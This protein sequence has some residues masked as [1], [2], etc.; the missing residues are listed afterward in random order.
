MKNQYLSNKK[1][2]ELINSKKYEGYENSIK[3]A[4]EFRYANLLNYLNKDNNYYN[5]ISIKLQHFINENLNF[6]NLKSYFFGFSKELLVH[7]LKVYFY[8]EIANN[9][10]FI[11]ELN[12]IKCDDKSVLN[13]NQN[14]FDPGFIDKMNNEYDNKM[15]KELFKILEENIKFIDMEKLH[16]IYFNEY[17]YIFKNILHILKS[18]YIFYAYTKYKIDDLE[19]EDNLIYQLFNIIEKK[20]KIQNF[21][22]IYFDT[23][24]D[25]NNYFELMK[26]TH[27][28]N[29]PWLYKYILLFLNIQIYCINI[30]FFL[31]LRLNILTKNNFKTLLNI[32]ITPSTNISKK[33]NF[34]DII[35]YTLK[36][37]EYSIFFL[38]ISVN[39]I[40][41]LDDINKYIKS[42]FSNNLFKFFLIYQ[43]NKNSP[44]IYEQNIQTLSNFLPHFH[45]I[46]TNFI[47]IKDNFVYKKILGDLLDGILVI[48]DNIS[49]ENDGIL[50]DQY[51]NNNNNNIFMIKNGVKIN[52]KNYELNNRDNDNTNEYLFDR[53]INKYLVK[54]MKKHIKKKE[55]FKNNIDINLF[56]KICIYLFNG[57][58][59]IL[60]VND[61]KKC[62][63]NIKTCLDYIKDDNIYQNAFSLKYFFNL[64]NY[65]NTEIVTNNIEITKHVSPYIYIESKNILLETSTLFF[66]YD[67]LKAYA[68]TS[69][70]VSNINSQLN[71]EEN[72]NEK[73]MFHPIILYNV[74]KLLL[75]FFANKICNFPIHTL[76]MF[77]HNLLSIYRILNVLIGTNA[78][79]INFEEVEN[80]LESLSKLSNNTDSII[81]ILEDTLYFKITNIL[82]TK[83]L[84]IKNIYITYIEYYYILIDFYSKYLY[85]NY[86]RGNKIFFGNNNFNFCFFKNMIIFFC[87]MLKINKCF[88]LLIEIKL[89]SYF[90]LPYGIQNSFVSIFTY[91][92]FLSLKYKELQCFTYEIVKTLLFLVKKININKL[93][94]YLFQIFSYSEHKEMER[95]EMAKNMNTDVD[96]NIFNSNVFLNN[97]SEHGQN[98]NDTFGNFQNNNM[99]CVNFSNF[100]IEKESMDIKENFRIDISFL[101]IYFLINDVKTV[102]LHKNLSN[103]ESE[104]NKNISKYSHKKSY[105]EEYDEALNKMEKKKMKITQQNKYEYNNF[106]NSN[107]NSY[108]K[109]V[110]S[111]HEIEEISF[112]NVFIITLIHLCEIDNNKINF[113]TDLLRLYDEEKKKN[114]FPCTEGILKLFKKVIN[115]KTGISFYSNIYKCFQRKI[116][117]ILDSIN[118]LVKKWTKW[119]FENCDNTFK[120]EKNIDINKLVNLFFISFYKY[121]KNYFLIINDFLN[122]IKIYNSNSTFDEFFFFIFSKY[123]NKVFI[124]N[125][126]SSFI[127]KISKFTILN[128]AL[129]IINYMLKISENVNTHTIKEFYTHYNNQNKLYLQNVK[130]E[131]SHIRNNNSSFLSY[132]YN[133]NDQDG[134]I[135]TEHTPYDLQLSKKN[136]ITF[137]NFVNNI[138]INHTNLLSKP[139]LYLHKKINIFQLHMA[140][141]NEYFT[142]ITTM[143]H[144]TDFLCIEKES[145]NNKLDFSHYR[146]N[147]E[148]FEKRYSNNFNLEYDNQVSSVE[149]L[150]QKPTINFNLNN[151]DFLENENTS[152]KNK[153][154]DKTRFDTNEFFEN[155]SVNMIHKNTINYNLMFQNF[156][157][158]IINI[159]EIIFQNNYVFFLSDFLLVHYEQ[160]EKNKKIFKYH[161]SNS[162]NYY[163]NMN[164]FINNYNINYYKNKDID[165]ENSKYKTYQKLNE[166]IINRVLLMY[167][168]I[169]EV[170]CR[171]KFI[172]K[173]NNISTNI[174]NQIFALFDTSHPIHNLFSKVCLNSLPKVSPFYFSKFFI[175]FHFFFIFFSFF[176]IFFH[177]FF[178]FFQFIILQND[179]VSKSLNNDILSIEKKHSNEKREILSISLFYF[180]MHNYKNI[181]TLYDNLNKYFCSNNFSSIYFMCKYRKGY[182]PL[183]SIITMFTGKIKFYYNKI[184]QV[185][186]KNMKIEYTKRILKI[187]KFLY[188][189]IRNNDLIDVSIYEELFDLLF[190]IITKYFEMGNNKEDIYKSYDIKSC[191][192]NKLKIFNLSL[193]FMNGVYLNLFNEKYKDENSQKNSNISEKKESLWKYIELH[194]NN[195]INKLKI[196]NYIFI[197]SYEHMPIYDKHVKKELYNYMYNINVISEIFDLVIK[198]LYTEEINIYKFI[199]QICY[200]RNMCNI[201]FNINYVNL[202][203]LLSSYC[204]LY[205]KKI[206]TANNVKDILS[207]N[208]NILIE[209]HGSISDDILIENIFQIFSEKNYYY[210]Y[211]LNLYENKAGNDQNEENCIFERKNNSLSIKNVLQNKMEL[212]EDDYIS[213]RLFEK[214]SKKKYGEKNFVF[215]I[216]NYCYCLNVQKNNLQNNTSVFN[217]HKENKNLINGNIHC[218]NET[219]PDIKLKNKIYKSILKNMDAIF[220]NK[221]TNNEKKKIK[222]TSLKFDENN[223]E[224]N[225]MN[226]WNDKIDRI[227]NIKN[228]KFEKIDRKKKDKK[229]TI[230]YEYSDNISK[231]FMFSKYFKNEIKCM[232]YINI[233]QSV[234]DSKIRLLLFLYKFIIILKYKKLFEIENYKKEEEFYLK[235]SNT[236]LNVPFV[237]FIY[238]A[239]CTFLVP[240][241]QI[242]KNS[243]YYV[244]ISNI[245]VNLFFI[246]NMHSYEQKK[247]K[248]SLENENQTKIPFIIN[249]NIENTNY[250]NNK[251]NEINNIDNNDSYFDDEYENS[252]YCDLFLYES[253][254]TNI[255]NN[256]NNIFYVLHRG[257][258]FISEIYRKQM[259]WQLQ[260]EGYNDIDNKNSKIENK[261]KKK[262]EKNSIEDS[263]MICNM[264]VFFSLFIR[265][266]IIHLHYFKLYNKNY[267]FL[268]NLN[269]LYVPNCILKHIYPAQNFNINLFISL[270]E[271]FYVSIRLYNNHF[272][273]IN[274]GRQ[275]DEDFKF[276][277]VDKKNKNSKQQNI[278]DNEKNKEINKKVINYVKNKQLDIYNSGD[279]IFNFNIYIRTLK[280]IL[281]ECYESHDMY[282]QNEENNKMSYFMEHILLYFLYNRINTIYEL[283]YSFYFK[284]IKVEKTKII[285]IVN[286]QIYKNLENILYDHVNKINTFLYNNQYYYFY[287]NTLILLTL[288]RQICLHIIKTDILTKFIYVPI[289]YHSMFDN[290]KNFNSIYYISNGEYIRNKNHITF[291]SLIVLIIKMLYIY[292]NDY[293]NF[294]ENAEFYFSENKSYNFSKK[295]KKIN[296]WNSE[297][298]EIDEMHTNS[299]FFENI[300]SIN[301]QINPKEMITGIQNDVTNQRNDY[302]SNNEINIQNKNAKHFEND[303]KNAKY[304]GKENL[305][306]R[307]YTNKEVVFFLSSIFN[308]IGKMSDRINF[309]FTKI[310]KINCL[311][312][313]EEAYLY[314]E[315]LTKISYY[316]SLYNINDFLISIMDKAVDHHLFYINRILE[317]FIFEKEMIIDPYS[318]YEVSA[319]SNSQDYINQNK[320]KKNGLSL[321]TQRILYICYKSI[322]NY[323]TIL[324]N[325]INN[326]YFYYSYFVIHF[327]I[328]ILK[329]TR[330]VT[331]IIEH[332]GRRNTTLIR[333]VKAN[334]GIS[335]VP[336]CLD[337]INTTKEKKKE[338]I[339]YT[340][341]VGGKSSSFC[342]YLSDNN[343]KS[344]ISNNSGEIIQYNKS[345]DEYTNTKRIYKNDNLFNFLPE[346]IQLKKYYN[347]LKEI[348]ER[349]AFLGAFLLEKLKI[350]CEDSCLK[351][352]LISN[353]CSYLIH[354]NATLLP[355][356]ICTNNFK[357]KCTLI[358]NYIVNIHKK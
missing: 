310:E 308:I 345:I 348:L 42:P 35:I 307:C 93:N 59:F 184:N 292:A 54:N 325:I 296:E 244:L 172:K 71:G 25:T 220:D 65:K 148:N 282:M 213:K 97:N 43:K 22:Q 196:N 205:N 142:N 81:T 331:T 333:T 198:G 284:C 173:I 56:L 259:N 51:I 203:N 185:Q 157:C 181:Y 186:C 57:E 39:N 104:Q 250:V 90:K 261:D 102:R 143:S 189:F 182:F 108:E 274:K 216:K 321:F 58:D 127:F 40:I 19:Y 46:L 69:T 301:L 27:T 133:E 134:N 260:N 208:K 323:N 217:L 248:N 1:I 356:N 245:I 341:G 263:K 190:F 289:I 55:F 298:I 121:L 18:C 228:N 235:K 124:D 162:D 44:N 201:F 117:Q 332:F 107:L 299:F 168:L 283:L 147:I 319:S 211:I 29:Y 304:K 140:N 20:I 47:F 338:K 100:K 62:Y 278:F 76:I 229:K 21:I 96:N 272:V 273:K 224:D 87:K 174:A 99:N 297:G 204:K 242:N 340:R 293:K 285:D 112:E 335:N 120:R 295:L 311:A 41:K 262:P 247:K 334:N 170:C 320:L 264:S 94:T 329:S 302:I 318:Q 30:F 291:C 86:D 13:D 225:K 130:V 183:L 122:N 98:N 230:Y 83:N 309:I 249:T 103:N 258:S 141:E 163:S 84:D 197:K 176:F 61:I 2:Y 266:I 52:N 255:K 200:N 351:Q 77:N 305:D 236:K 11:L 314:V 53:D 223:N 14:V 149:N 135:H 16:L 3:E 199:I 358:Y 180:F 75:E 132:P 346:V 336:I 28:E 353:I 131:K 80:N 4:F 85:N 17:F 32:F 128:T 105:N 303:N 159:L 5:I 151:N 79:L 271:V 15:D 246:I 177:F 146:N 324:L 339:Y 138:I 111:N 126:S 357:K 82:K 118:T 352:I 269:A 36:Q 175:F 355:A 129:Y 88:P 241:I 50:G 114:I 347:I 342:Q 254:S 145:V 6:G 281:T 327:Y 350:L 34:N 167:S 343:S 106:Y 23:Y 169:L 73:G 192:F 119:T 286:K 276:D 300:S 287:I 191:E 171:F 267:Y 210:K 24:N 214:K 256:N 240:S 315:L 206:D 38:L 221:N 153:N 328:L 316:C 322:L 277:E 89:F 48:D 67:Y 45:D 275:F 26:T 231:S 63:K 257:S 252:Y 33:N 243:F 251:Q 101:K 115:K 72:E 344:D 233:T 313:L 238:E 354:I 194:F 268:K 31:Q 253:Y 10:S 49:V 64:Y 70:N 113:V 349:S 156:F 78:N 317:K 164:F 294:E 239:M 150:F 187:L 136:T 95:R 160:S 144:V 222:N 66:A 212:L 226:N 232:K 312:A 166:Q 155:N 219:N 227:Q 265:C 8:N 234:Y 123:I 337:I 37:K 279:N 306:G 280:E 74:N 139:E 330:L 290:N 116:E 68:D 158:H 161:L 178:I 270:L 288:N 152:N 110:N 165:L 193:H 137:N 9:D 92:L 125:F 237:F 179:I 91:L 60:F 218:N 7:S 12:S 195:F 154:Y 109:T 215:D 326:Q 202:N 207:N 188:F 209:K